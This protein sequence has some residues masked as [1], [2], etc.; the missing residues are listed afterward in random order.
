MP[1]CPEQW[2]LDV[3]ERYHKAVGIVTSLSTGSIVLPVLFLRNIA[4]APEGTSIA[5]SFNKWIYTG[6]ALLGISVL[7]AIV[8]C[9]AS[10]KWVKLAWAKPADMFGRVVTSTG[11]ERILDVSYF[12]MIAGFLTGFG[13]IVI[14]MSTHIR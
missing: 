13:A 6:W 5:E 3:N 2:K 9:Y 7:G 10:A 4:G 8:Y 1:E 11:V 12:A 14:F